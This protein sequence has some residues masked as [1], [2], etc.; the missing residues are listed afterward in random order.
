M[1]W[2]TQI[3]FPRLPGLEG[4]LKLAHGQHYGTVN[5]AAT[6]DIPSS[7]LIQVLP[8]LLPANVAGKVAED[9]PNI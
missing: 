7:V 9:D 6:S 8:A 5:E 4:M 2:N 3:T 1:L